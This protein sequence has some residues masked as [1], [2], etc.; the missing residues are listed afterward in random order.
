MLKVDIKI[1]QKL[2]VQVPSIEKRTGASCPPGLERQLAY[3]FSQIS[4]NSDFK[5]NRGHVLMYI[6]NGLVHHWAEIIDQHPDETNASGVY[7]RMK[8]AGFGYD[9]A[10]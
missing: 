3:C 7:R 2:R 4:A 8:K 10:V 5:A 9:F 1:Q 6:Q